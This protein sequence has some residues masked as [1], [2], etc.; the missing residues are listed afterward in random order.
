MNQIGGNPMRDQYRLLT[1]ALSCLISAC[2]SLHSPDYDDELMDP[3]FLDSGATTM[4]VD[5]LDTLPASSEELPVRALADDEQSGGAR[6]YDPAFRQVAPHNQV[7]HFGFDK[8]R[9]SKVDEQVINLQADYLAAHPKSKLLLI[10]HADERGSR[11]YNVA[12][13]FRRAKAVAQRFYQLG[14]AKSQVRLL[15]FGEEQPVAFMHNQSA[16]AK[17]R[18]VDL[19]YEVKE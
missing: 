13:G 5:D 9:L 11:E 6:G 10:G 16:W 8:S 4:S 2:G 1:I 3:L 17:N 19:V 12:L 7:V 14:A 18:R 15:S